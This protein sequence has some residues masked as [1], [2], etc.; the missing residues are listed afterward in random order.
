V[1]TFLP[2]AGFDASAAVLDDARLG[3]QRVET[4]QIL[5]ALVFPSY[6]GWKNHPATRMWRGFTQGLVSYGIAMCDEWERRGHADAVR[7]SLLQFAGG[8][9]RSQEE[10]LVAGLLPPWTGLPDLHVSHRAALARK[11]PE[12]Y[13]G[14][15]PDVD[16]EQP[17]HWPAPLFPRW[18]M[19]RGDEVEVP[20]ADRR[21]AAVAA[22][23]SAPGPT[24]WVRG[25]PYDDAAPPLDDLRPAVVDRPPGKIS[26]SIARPPTPEDEAAVQA[27]VT[28]PPFLFVYPEPLLGDPRVRAAMPQ[29]ALVVL[30]GV[31]GSPELPDAEVLTIPQ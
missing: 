14:H 25:G 15:F 17:Y 27:E 24:V 16:P 8:S 1:Q 19:R 5:R 31:S 10:L 13:T 28:T 2:Y 11:L 18:P 9:A 4:L 29:P 3:K 20:D 30:E 23:L 7:T 12:H 22:A 26:P 6:K 21:A